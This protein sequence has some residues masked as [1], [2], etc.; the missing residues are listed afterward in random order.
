[1][2]QA[3]VTAR[4][5][6]YGLLVKGKEEVVV[7]LKNVSVTCSAQ[8]QLGRVAVQVQLQKRDCWPSRGVVSFPC[9]R[10]LGGSGTGSCH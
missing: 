1:M 5:Y 4:R 9:G 8:G 7:P 2:A 3:R 6:A 10:V